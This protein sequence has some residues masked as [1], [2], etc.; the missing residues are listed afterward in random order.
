MSTK[1]RP[2]W[3]LRNAH[4]QT[5]WAGLMR[6]RVPLATRRERLELPDGDFLDL[7]GWTAGAARW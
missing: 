6:R 5:L 7:T 2:A 4:A 3:W 1:F